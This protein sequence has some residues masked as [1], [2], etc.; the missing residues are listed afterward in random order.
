MTRTTRIAL[1]FALCSAALTAGGIA[2][3]D[4]AMKP[5][6]EA[7]KSDSG[8]MMKTDDKAIADC[9]EKAGMEA[10]QMKKDEAMKTCDA[11][12]MAPAK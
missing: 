4:D 7:M 12:G 9:K 3:A 1:A 5:A 6:A 2:R 11:M 10:D 8:G